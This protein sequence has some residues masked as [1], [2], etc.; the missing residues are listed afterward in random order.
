MPVE[1]LSFEK[2]LA[3]FGTIHATVYLYKML[4]G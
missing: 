3:T 2:K 4:V 1:G